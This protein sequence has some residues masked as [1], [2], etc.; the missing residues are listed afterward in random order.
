MKSKSDTLRKQLTDRIRRLAHGND[1]SPRTTAK[2]VLE[3]R[4]EAERR[5][6]RGSGQQK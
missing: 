5:P 3:Q 6:R 1:P 4:P 2:Q